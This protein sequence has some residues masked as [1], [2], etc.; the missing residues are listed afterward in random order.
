LIVTYSAPHYLS[1]TLPFQVQA[2]LYEGSHDIEIHTTI[3][4]DASGFDPGATTT[5]GVENADG[6]QGVAVPGRNSALFAASNDAFRFTPITPYS[7]TWQPGSLNGASQVVNPLSTTTYSVQV[8]DGSACELELEAPPVYVSTCQVQMDLHLLIEGYY[9]GNG[10]MQSVVSNAG[11]S[12][13]VNLCDSITVELRSSVSPFQLVASTKT[14]MDISGFAE[15]LFTVPY[16]DYYLAVEHQ[17]ALQTW[18]AQPLHLDASVMI[19]DFT[20]AA[21]KAFGNN[22]VEVE[23]GKWALFSGD[24]NRDESIDLIDAGLLEASVNSFQFGYLNTD[25]NGDG[26]VDLLDSMPLESNIVQ[27]IFSAHP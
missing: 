16:G 20:I 11:V 23:S 21:S 9:I 17:N 26:N 14:I 19:Y 13:N 1:A 10:Q 22:L 6:T 18:S 12:S 27:F 24:L 2:I 5:Q 25:I 8:S 15:C 4:S 3:I 7:Y